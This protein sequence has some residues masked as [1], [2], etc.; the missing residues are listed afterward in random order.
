MPFVTQ[1]AK[2]LEIV[3]SLPLPRKWRHICSDPNLKGMPK[4]YFVLIKISYLVLQQY[5]CD[6]KYL[7]YQH[8]IDERQRYVLVGI[9]NNIDL[10][11][12]SFPLIWPNMILDSNTRMFIFYFLIICLFCFCLLLFLC[13]VCRFVCLFVCLFVLL[14]FYSPLSKFT[15]SIKRC[16]FTFDKFR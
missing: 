8:I 7:F 3:P 5:T 4:Q 10:M 15:D 13:F 1:T 6:W 12:V 9:R 11:A 16:M 14:F 2:T